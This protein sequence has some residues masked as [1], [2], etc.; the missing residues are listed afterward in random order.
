MARGENARATRRVA[1]T[2]IGKLRIG[3]LFL[4]RIICSSENKG[5]NAV[6]NLFA[7][8]ALIAVATLCSSIPAASVPGVT[9]DEIRVGSITDLTGPAA[10]LGQEISA[11]MRLYLSYVNDQGGIHNRRVKLIVE[12]DGYQPPRSIAAFRKLVDRDQVFCF[13]ANLGSSTNLAVFPFIERE[14]IP[15]ITPA[16]YN[17]ALYTPSRHYVFAMNPSYA[18]QSGIIVRYIVEVEQAESPRLGV[19]YQDD[20]YGRDGL[21]GLREAA[22]HYGLPIVA[23]ESHR[24]GAVDL[25]TQVLNL[26]KA[27]PTHVVLC[28]LPRET[29]AIL[30][31]AHRLG[32]QPR[33]LGS[34]PAAVDKTVELAGEAAATFAGVQVADLRGDPLSPQVAFYYELTKKEDPGR[35]HFSYHA[36]GFGLAQILVEGLRRAGPDLTRDK[37]VAAMESFDDWTGSVLPPLTYGP[38]VRGGKRT[39]AIVSTVD[40]KRH[41]LVRATDWIYYERPGDSSDGK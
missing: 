8:L 10:F 18:T 21:A 9:D 4:S 14:R 15:L 36:F 32:W 6:K 11:G 26:K 3:S 29:A 22:A 25:G 13:V 30:Q 39:A 37:L 23:E 27:D 38:G 19:I 34:T 35:T 12:D 28:T 5:E 1:P 33:F 24:R 2:P 40:P 16:C 7:L 20:D 31:E 17:S 41:V